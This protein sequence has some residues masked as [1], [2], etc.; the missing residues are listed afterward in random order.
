MKKA[1]LATVIALCTTSA[2]AAETAVL[3]VK[4]T[5]TN[6]A[7]TPEIG[8]G[9]VID[10]GRINLGGLSATTNNVIGEKEVPV[11]ITCTAAT[12]VGFKVQDDRK[13]SNAQ[14][15]VEVHGNADMTDAYYTYGVGTTTGGVKIGNY[16]LWMKDVTANGATVDAIIKNDD[17]SAD[18]W[19]KSVVPRSDAFTTSAFATTGTTEPLAI[20]TAGFNFV[21]NLVI[22]D[23]ATLAITDDT[24][25]DGQA[26]LSLV[27][28]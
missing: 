28:L 27:Y 11:T 3:K 24:Q 13:D 5:L 18:K 21:S 8:N 4:G 12:K 25:L 20:T 9:G 17:W 22:R 23:T 15:P 16:G 2:F 10:Y 14:L 1:I 19:Q 26:T 7:C 6:S